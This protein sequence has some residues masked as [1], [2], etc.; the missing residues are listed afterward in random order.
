M[1]S[2]CLCSW[3]D[4]PFLKIL[5]AGVKRNTK[6][7]YEFI[8]HDN[9]SED[10][11]EEWLK[12]NGIQYTRSETN[13]GVAAVNYAVERA[14]YRYIVDI[15]ADMYPL[16]GWDIEILKQIKTF[17]RE[18]ID[19]W[20]ISSCLIEPRGANPEYTIVNC[21]TTPE[22]FDETQLLAQYA[23]NIKPKIDTTQYSHPIVMPKAQWDKM[24]GVD[25]EYPYG[26]ATD[27]DIAARAYSV[28]CRHFKMLGRSRV[29][30]FVG[31]TI[32]K[33]PADR[34]N[35]EPVFFRKW[36]ITVQ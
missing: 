31:Q 30:H 14:S 6:V 18:K 34:P 2:I 20:M 15:N 23:F 27:H 3:N 11:T 22:S 8:V 25:T 21:G 19:K 26:L 32:R 29:Y 9:G 28:G 24:G 36:G 1:F 7:K 17:E 13:E 16:P 4:L 35:A 5:Y 33:L 10:G 12:E